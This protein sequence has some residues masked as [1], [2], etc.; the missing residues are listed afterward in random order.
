MSIRTIT[1]LTGLGLAASLAA[2]NTN[3]TSVQTQSFAGI[4]NFSG[5]FLFDQVNAADFDPNPANVNL[6]GVQITATATISDGLLE[7]DNDGIDPAVINSAELGA[8]I[9]LTSDTL[10]LALPG[11]SPVTSGSFNLAG[12]NGDGGTFDS[13]PL[14]EPDYDQLVGQNITDIDLAS[15]T[16]AFAAIFAG[17]GQFDIDYDALSI[18]DFGGVGGVSFAGTPVNVDLEVEVVYTYK[19]VPAPAGLAAF[20]IFGLAA[21]RRRR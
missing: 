6:L 21:A 4:P 2:A 5:E 17:A 3:Q 14:S 13:Q 15:F 8:S 18:F 10:P 11:V 12:N 19:I 16:G 7:G 20:G 1:A 9:A